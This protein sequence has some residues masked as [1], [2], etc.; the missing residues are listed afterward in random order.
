M[1]NTILY[2]VMHDEK[3][4]KLYHTEQN[5]RVVELF[6]AKFGAKIMNVGI[7]AVVKIRRIAL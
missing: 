7:R 1:E 4:G 2:I 3:T 6:G 5:R